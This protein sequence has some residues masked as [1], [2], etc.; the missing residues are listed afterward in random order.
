[1]GTFR[2][3][4]ENSEQNITPV[5]FDILAPDGITSLLPEGVK[6]VFHC[7]PKSLQLNYQKELSTVKTRGG[8]V[9]FHWGDSLYTLTFDNAS[10][11]FMRMYT[12]LS[13]TTNSSGQG[14][15]QTLAYDRVTDYLA[16][17]HN[18]AAIY[19]SQ[20]QIALSGIVQCVF[21]NGIYNGWFQNDFQISESSDSPYQFTFSSTFVIDNEVMS[22]KTREQLG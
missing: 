20:G 18:N 17:F 11:A 8:F 14:R 5:I 10:G 2:T 1:M 19:D 12:G 21:A 7:N 16:L 13:A 6:F 15:R 9:E 4:L 22:F 3:D